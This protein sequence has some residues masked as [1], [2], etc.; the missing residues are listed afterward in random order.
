VIYDEAQRGPAN[1]GTGWKD[2]P[3]VVAA[4]VAVKYDPSR[5]V[6][7]NNDD[8]IFEQNGQAE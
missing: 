2:T 7:N 6:P 5:L 4:V 1:S 8:V 3:L